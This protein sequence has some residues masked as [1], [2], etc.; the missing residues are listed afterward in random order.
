MQA[1]ANCNARL[2]SLENRPEA[3]VEEEGVQDIMAW[4]TH[5]EVSTRKTREGMLSCE[6]AHGQLKN[7]QAVSQQA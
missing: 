2:S 5:M 4:L 7:A 6:A 3:A 1:M